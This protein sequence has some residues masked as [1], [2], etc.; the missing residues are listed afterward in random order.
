MTDLQLERLNYFFVH[1]FNN[2]FLWE[3]R[4][5]AEAGVKNLSTKE[6]HVIAAVSSL[7]T[8][9]Q[10]TMSQIAGTLHISVGALTTAVNTLIRKGYLARAKDDKDRR[11]VLVYLTDSGR[12]MNG[13]HD[14]FHALM[15]ENVQKVI[16]ESD[17]ETLTASLGQLS[18]FFESL[19]KEG[20][21]DK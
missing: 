17:L 16:G 2:I 5:L 13:K 10:N 3:E 20:T 12:E 19:A 14:A 6:M 11:R 1:T 18:A 7:G 8:T 9:K 4:A 15:I 21:G